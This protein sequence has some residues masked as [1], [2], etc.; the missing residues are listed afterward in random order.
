MSDN[1]LIRSTSPEKPEVGR[2]LPLPSLIYLL[3]CSKQM[4]YDLELAALNRSVNHL[5]VAKLEWE[6][7]VA[8]REAAGVARWLIENREELLQQS[9]RTLEV[10]GAAEFPG[11][12]TITGPKAGLDALLGKPG[13]SKG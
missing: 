1:E 12:A 6:E 5:K 3:E 7:A 10:H 11:Q 13:S 9:S 2:P 8:Q 4:L